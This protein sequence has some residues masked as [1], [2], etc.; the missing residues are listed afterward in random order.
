VTPTQ[1]LVTIDIGLIQWIESA[2][3]VDCGPSREVVEALHKRVELAYA[4]GR[5]PELD[6]G[7]V[8]DTM[9][10][11]DGGWLKLYE[12]RP[13]QRLRGWHRLR[14]GS[15]AVPRGRLAEVARVLDGLTLALGS[16]CDEMLREYD[17]YRVG[18]PATWPED[19][20]WWA[21]HVEERA[22]VLT[23]MAEHDMCGFCTWCQ[24]V[25][26]RDQCEAILRAASGK[27]AA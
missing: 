9:K 27:A 24:I 5:D 14:H 12:L 10:A 17:L 19:D 13:I 22:Q 7:L 16:E 6:S 8:D 4:E 11:L 21:I 20:Q 1:D 15:I 26:L 23:S 3:C 2:L 18:E 25:Q